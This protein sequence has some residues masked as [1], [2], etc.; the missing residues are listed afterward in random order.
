MVGRRAGRGFLLK[1]LRPI[2]RKTA[3]GVTATGVVLTAT[4]TLT[5]VATDT[6]LPTV[7]LAAASSLTTAATI[8]EPGVA[9]LVAASTLT[10]TM[11]PATV[12]G[13][14]ARSEER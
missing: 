7:A 4:S 1:P 13:L 10:P 11:A 5:A 14:S 3:P 12:V 9:A 2:V 8:T 6:V